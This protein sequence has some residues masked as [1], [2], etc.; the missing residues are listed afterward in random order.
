MHPDLWS[1]CK[2][3]LE[4]NLQATETNGYGIYVVFW[5]GDQRK[6]KIPSP[7]KGITMPNFPAELEQSLTSLIDDDKKN[8]I[9]AIVIDVS[10]L[11]SPSKQ[12]KKYPKKLNPEFKNRLR[13]YR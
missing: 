2:K 13:Y 9:T 7:S 8:K 11:L 6:P 3:Q 12:K 5:F 4:V 1:A 10:P